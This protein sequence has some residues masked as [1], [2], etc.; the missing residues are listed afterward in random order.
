M[1]PR[2]STFFFYQIRSDNN[3][4]VPF[5]NAPFP[6]PGLYYLTP[7]FPSNCLTITQL[8]Q[9]HLAH[10]LAPVPGCK[11][12]LVANFEK[13]II[14]NRGGI[15]KTL[16]KEAEKRGMNINAGNNQ[17][18]GKKRQDWVDDVGVGEDEN[19]NS[20]G[21]REEMESDNECTSGFL[22]TRFYYLA[23]GFDPRMLLKRELAVILKSHDVNAVGGKHELVETF[24]AVVAGLRKK[25][26]IA[27]EKKRSA[28]VS[29]NTNKVKNNKA[30][31]TL[32]Q[33]PSRRTSTVSNF[34]P[35]S[36]VPADS[37]S[38]LGII[39]VPV[40]PAPQDPTN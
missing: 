20:D 12:D 22:D 21:E 36:D 28:G 7:G 26:V 1:A 11:A 17:S 13:S 4:H 23:P 6:P 40:F 30:N 16:A 8:S 5:P 27:E 37:E 9:I 31:I 14:R 35:G 3:F 2:F 34:E 33:L 10:D 19:E 15:L 32:N 39:P 25:V 38:E 29:R 24:T 18:K